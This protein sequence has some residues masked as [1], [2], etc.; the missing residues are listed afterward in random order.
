MERAEL[1]TPGHVR[2]KSREFPDRTISHTSPEP[3]KLN[4]EF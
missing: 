2:D 3:V 1:A 4:Y